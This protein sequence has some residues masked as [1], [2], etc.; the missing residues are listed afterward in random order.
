[1]EQK[2]EIEKGRGFATI[3]SGGVMTFEVQGISERDDIRQK[4]YQNLYSRYI[5]DNRTMMVGDFMVPLWGEGHNLYPQEVF[6]ITSENKL[7]PEV[8]KKQ[9]KF[10]FGKG[11]RLYKEVIQG[12][13][14]KMRRVR[15][16]VEIPEI[17]E[18]LDSW[19]DMGYDSVWDYLKNRIVDFYYVNT[20]CSK[21][22]Y[23]VSRRTDR[24]IK[25]ALKVR[26][27]TYIGA[28]EARLATS[29]KSLT[30]RIK[31]SDCRYV[32]L[33]DWMNPN[34]Y[35]YEV[36]HRFDPITPFKYPTAVSFECDKT[37]TKWIYA[38]NDWFKG[39]LEWIKASNLSP[40][41]LNSYLK[42]AL[43]A[44]IHVIIPGSWYNAQRDI[45]QNICSEN[46]RSDVP[47][48]SEYRGIKL[49][50]NDNQPIPFYET[51]LDELIANEL[52]KITSLMAGEGKNQ[53][54]L[55]ATTKWGKDEGWEFKEFPGKFQEFFKTVIDYDKRADQVTLAGKGVPPSISGVDKDGSI[56]N[57]G[58]EVYYNYLIYIASLVWDEYLVMKDINRAIHLNFPYTKKEKIKLG[59][60]I[61]IPAKL[62]DT[63]PSDRPGQTVT[64]DNKSNL[65]KTEEQ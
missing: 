53:G 37:F 40:K 36:Y 35:D 19:E 6:S 3:P 14:E 8:I 33:A 7:I 22:H 60:W 15:V 59:F 34:K 56:S 21:W 49:I 43:N 42:N 17:E 10:L 58:S 18:W 23:N 39:L 5:F 29:E 38:F 57:S 52:R 65:Q 54:K 46:L 44:H 25:N 41:Y 9:V 4:E 45:L 62:Q 20:V 12:E 2:I 61:D 47:V 16:P 13:G 24:T 51:M 1:M 50:S 32:I 55:Y 64:A 30:K 28:D 27:L 26:A 63:T 11:P 31:N 48:Q